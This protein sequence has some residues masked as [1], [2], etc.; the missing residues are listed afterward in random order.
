MKKQI[1]KDQLFTSLKLEVI[2]HLNGVS[3]QNMTVPIPHHEG[4]LVKD[5]INEVEKE[6]EPGI[7]YMGEYIKTLSSI[8]RSKK[9]K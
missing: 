2:N 7:V 4:I 6:T 9:R 1:L 8:V 5:L 3:N